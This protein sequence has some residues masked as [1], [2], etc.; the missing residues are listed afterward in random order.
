MKQ[1][2]ERNH[3][4][5]YHAGLASTWLLF[6]AVTNRYSDIHM[7]SIFP[8]MFPVLLMA[9]SYGLGWGFVFAAASTLA[10]MP[11]GYM[12]HHDLHDL[13]WAALITYLKLTL[14]TAGV[15]FGKQLVE[16]RRQG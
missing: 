3:R 8:F 4:F 10:A 11:G 9:W 2:L 12:Q 16:R 6:L 7:I 13:Y 15:I 1:F 14:V 5:L